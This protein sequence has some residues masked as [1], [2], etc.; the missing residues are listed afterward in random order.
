M[1]NDSSNSHDDGKMIEMILM[2]MRKMT[3]R[4]IKMMMMKVMMMM[5]HVSDDIW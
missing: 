5:L 3:M 4:T 1:L 2:R